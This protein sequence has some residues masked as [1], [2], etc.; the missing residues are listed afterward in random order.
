[1]AHQSLIGLFIVV[2]VIEK[3]ANGDMSNLDNETLQAL[4]SLQLPHMPQEM[5]GDDMN[6]LPSIRIMVVADIDL[7]SSA[8]LAEYCLQQRNALF[9]ASRIDLCIACGPFC[10]DEDARPYLTGKQERMKTNTRNARRSYPTNHLRN[11][12][13]HLHNSSGTSSSSHEGTLPP[14]PFCRS[15]EETAGL[16]GLITAS[17]SQLESIVCRVVYCPGSSD[18]ITTMMST[19]QLASHPDRTN[20][21]NESDQQP[22]NRVSRVGSTDNR[23]LTPN[24]RNIH[25]Q[26]LP[27]APALGCAGLIHLDSSDTIMSVKKAQRSKRTWGRRRSSGNTMDGTTSSDDDDERGNNNDDEMEKLSEIMTQSQTRYDWT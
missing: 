26:W 14:N 27:L 10:R 12:L 25:R 2:S 1:M 9:D 4:A 15:R 17:L 3:E 21:K 7:P 24:S 20:D 5:N 23:R 13:S 18:P 19:A 8:A 11:S 22:P 6:D 16:E